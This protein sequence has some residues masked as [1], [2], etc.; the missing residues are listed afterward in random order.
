[1]T[2]EGAISK[3]IALSQWRCSIK[4]CGPNAHKGCN[5]CIESRKKSAEECISELKETE[6]KNGHWIERSLPN[7]LG[8]SKFCSIC[9]SNYGM[10]HEIYNYCPNCGADMR[11]EQE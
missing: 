11:G 3:L 9:G 8:I 4:N 5:V 1:M 6:R 10:P 2:R 7:L